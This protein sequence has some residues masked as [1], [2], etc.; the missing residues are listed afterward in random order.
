M[1]AEG[2]FILPKWARELDGAAGRDA[3]ATEASFELGVSR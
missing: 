3:E 2:V 1:E